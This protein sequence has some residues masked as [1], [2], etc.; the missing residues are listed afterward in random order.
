MASDE[1]ID[2]PD[3]LDDLIIIDEIYSPISSPKHSDNLFSIIKTELLDEY[4]E[5]SL[6]EMLT[7]I[8]SCPNT[9]DELKTSSEIPVTMETAKS[10]QDILTFMNG[11]I[12]DEGVDVEVP[13]VPRVLTRKKRPRLVR[14][15]RDYYT[16]AKKSR[17]VQLGR[18]YF[19]KRR[20]RTILTKV[21][22]KKVIPDPMN[23]DLVIV[24]VL[25]LALALAPRP[26]LSP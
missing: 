24:L 18:N 13:V 17:I 6:S 10:S 2:E 21:T 25:A 1:A 11:I 3:D 7:I 12:P 14:I 15:D 5:D 20:L 22:A 26:S 23:I 8:P 19:T 9:L 4:D 16:Y